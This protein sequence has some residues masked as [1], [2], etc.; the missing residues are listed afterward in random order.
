MSAVA[1]PT[2]GKNT[3]TESFDYGQLDHAVADQA[4]Q[5]VA[6]I[7]SRWQA[8]II[9]TGRDLARIKAALPP[10][11]FSR[12]L[13]A[14]FRMTERTARNYIGAAGMVDALPAE[15]AEIISALPPTAIYA[16]ATPDLSDTARAKIIEQVVTG[17]AADL[18]VIRDTVAKARR[19]IADEAEAERTAKRRA[20]RT[21]EENAAQERKERARQRKTD[22]QQE[23]WRREQ[24]EKE[25]L[26]AEFAAIITAAQ[27]DAGRAEL[28]DLLKRIDPYSLMAALRT[29]L[30]EVPA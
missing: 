13:D 18:G 12:W 16:L 4:R 6:A 29:A 22:V 20:K 25:A 26:A 5:A 9:E 23:Q 21:P 28:S 19:L 1:M 11:T 17:Q 14:E 27:T 30:G 3:V 7:R 8:S 2:M 10:R 15:K 24:Q